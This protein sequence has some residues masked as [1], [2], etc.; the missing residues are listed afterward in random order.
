MLEDLAGALRAIALFPIFVVAPGYVAAF[1]DVFGFRSR[2][3]SFHLALSLVLSISLCPILAYMI[4][5]FV[6]MAV[7]WALYP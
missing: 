7:V 3:L 4:G 1:L 5:R 2:S 6:S